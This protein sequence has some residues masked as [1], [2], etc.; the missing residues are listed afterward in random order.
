MRALVEL[1]PAWVWAGLVGLLLAGLVGG[2]Q[3]IRLAA[4]HADLSDE[5]AAHSSYRTEVAERDR[6]AALVAL[7]ETKRRQARNEEVERNAAEQLEVAQADAASAGDALQRLE[8][9]YAESER[10]SRACGDSITAQ[11]GEAA[12]AEARVRAHVLGRVGAAAGLYAAAAD[13]NRVRGQACEA[14][15]DSL[16]Q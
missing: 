2:A 6:R 8:L 13:D 12:E 1:V 14:S 15:Y 4:A 10:R 11:L 9:R 7:E 5:K 16:T 3:Q